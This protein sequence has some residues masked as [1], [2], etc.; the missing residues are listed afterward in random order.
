MLGRWNHPEAL[1][2]LLPRLSDPDPS[3]RTA[4]ATSLGLLGRG[5]HAPDEAGRTR[6]VEALLA[7]PG[8]QGEAGIAFER[9]RLTALGRLGGVSAQRAL[10]AGLGREDERLRSAAAEGLAVL[11]HTRQAPPVDGEAD[12]LAGLLLKGEVGVRRP[13][14]RA[15]ARLD[16]ASARPGLL[17]GVKDPDGEVRWGCVKGLGKWALAPDVA[18]L[19]ERLADPMP[20]VAAEAARSLATARRS[21]DAPTALKATAALA[22]WLE[23]LSAQPQLTTLQAAQLIALVDG[24]PLPGLAPGL[25]A[26]VD[27]LS[28]LAGATPWVGRIAC[29]VARA[30]DQ[31]DGASP[32]AAPAAL[33]R[34]VP[35]DLPAGV[36]ER[37]R[38]EALAGGGGTPEAKGQALAALV[39][40]SAEGQT[41]RLESLSELPFASAALPVLEAGL[42]ESDPVVASAAAAL[43]KRWKRAE[44]LPAV[45]AVAE[46]LDALA[47]DEELSQSIAAAL[48][49][50]GETLEGWSARWRN[51][52]RPLVRAAARPKGEEE[53][54]PFAVR[55]ERHP[56][57]A[58]LHWRLETARGPVELQLSPNVGGREL[59]AQFAAGLFNGLRFHRQVPGFVVQG[60]DPRGDGHGGPPFSFVSDCDEG[61]HVPGAIG[62]ALSGPDTSGSQWFIDL[63]PQPHLDGRY[64]V[65]GQLTSGM[66]VAVQLVEGDAMGP[67]TPLP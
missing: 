19:V 1:G 33:A 53:R 26:L 38:V 15:L 40:K 66:E 44:L 54:L 2:L 6:A 37:F 4:A 12:A 56:N 36:L 17:Y 24:P 23:G 55:S 51:D 22:S 34:C 10:L 21:A 50:G 43:A 13:A 60:G 62:L 8:L 49:L 45:R 32:S 39:L 18:Y 63:T 52:A 5:W 3:T 28:K 47:L 7:V 65:V 46:R 29:R 31:L 16:H 20:Q 35:G 61:R 57:V 64:P 59:A 27:H 11:H 67:A 25:D 48:E 14:A 41:A 42:K 30:R 9:E 58:P